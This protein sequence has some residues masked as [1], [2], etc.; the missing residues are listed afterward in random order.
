MPD[1]RVEVPL[2]FDAFY[3]RVARE[4]LQFEW[5]DVMLG[6]NDY[7]RKRLKNGV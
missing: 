3:W 7:V 1:W 2:F 4:T 5:P 6:E